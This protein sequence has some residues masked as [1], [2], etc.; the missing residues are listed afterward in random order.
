MASLKLETGRR[1]LRQ[2]VNEGHYSLTNF[3]SENNTYQVDDMYCCFLVDIYRFKQPIIDT[4]DY[5][6]PALICSTASSADLV[7]ISA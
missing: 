2:F 1:R 7:A 5:L 6:L 3:K 4:G